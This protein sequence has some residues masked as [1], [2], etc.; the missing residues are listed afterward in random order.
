MLRGDPTWHTSSTGPMS[1]PSSRDAVATRARRSPARRRSSTRRRRSF[2]R[3]PWWAAT[4]SG[5]RRSPRRWARRSDIRR[6]LTNT[7]VVR[8]SRT[9]AAM[10]SITSPNCSVED[11]AANSVSGSSMRTESFRACP[12]STMAVGSVA[13]TPL[14]RRAVVLDGSLC[15]RQSDALRSPSELEMLEALEGE[16]QVRASLV[17]GQGVD[18]VHDHGVARR[19]ARPGCARR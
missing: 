18:L 17:A 15:G 19:R 5:P 4:C 13:A 14:S 6:V 16:G 10:R 7:R 3:L 12:Q 11:T 9:W 8:C 2:D 1:M